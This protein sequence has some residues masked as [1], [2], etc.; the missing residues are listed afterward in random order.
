MIQAFSDFLAITSRKMYIVGPLVSQTK[1]AEAAE[2]KL[3]EKSPE[4][5]AFMDRVLQTRGERSM[6]Y[7]CLARSPT[8]APPIELMI[9]FS[10]GTAWWP[11]NPEKVW[12]FLDILLEKQIPFVSFS[13][14]PCS[15]RPDQSHLY[16]SWLGLHRFLSFPRTSPRKW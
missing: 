8:L 3:A 10:L 4:V 15:A 14:S 16:R 5:T 6:L 11:S 2:K 9:Q 12:S 1:R 13:R 7:V